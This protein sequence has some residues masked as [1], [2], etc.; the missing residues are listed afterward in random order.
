M[1]G[2]GGDTI[3]AALQFVHYVYKKESDFS[4]TVQFNVS[5]NASGVFDQPKSKRQ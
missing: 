3:A 5:D 1:E 2:D 4:G